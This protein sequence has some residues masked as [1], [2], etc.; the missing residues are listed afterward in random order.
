M[1]FENWIYVAVAGGVTL[2]CFLCMCVK[3]CNGKKK[4]AKPASYNPPGKT[5]MKSKHRH[6]NSRAKF[7]R[8]KS[9]SGRG[10]ANNIQ[11]DDEFIP[12]PPKG[13]PPTESSTSVEVG[14]EGLDSAN[15]ALPPLPGLC[16]DLGT[17]AAG[18]VGPAG[19]FIINVNDD[20]GI[21]LINED[22]EDDDNGFE[23]SQIEIDDVEV[24]DDM[25]LRL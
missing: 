18:I 1:I 15:T 10:R 25:P 7:L 6:Q 4:V 13:P 8:V 23:I 5:K 11:V 20:D 22:Y 16:M 12:P 9:P 21:Q 17:L 19:G 24:L 2:C 14:I 3:C